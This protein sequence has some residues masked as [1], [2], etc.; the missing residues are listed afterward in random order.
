MALGVPLGGGPN[1][2]RVD[3]RHVLEPLDG[4]APS[5]HFVGTLG[6]ERLL[7]PRS[8]EPRA[9]EAEVPPASFTISP[10]SAQVW[11]AHPVCA[12]V[13]ASEAVP[14]IRSRATGPVTVVAPGY[15]PVTVDPATVGEIVLQRAP[16]IGSLVVAAA[17]GDQVRV[18]GLAV[19]TD[20]D[21]VVVKD[22]REGTVVVQV[23]G[24]GRSFREELAA[25]EGYGL[26]VRVPPP[27]VW[28][29]R[30]AANS[31]AISAEGR[32]R[33]GQLV[34]E[35]GDAV[36]RLTGSHSEEG[37]A[38]ANI[39]LADRR[40]RAVRDALVAAGMPADRLVVTPSRELDR[41]AP[42]DQRAVLI[43]AVGR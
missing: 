17:P 30:F 37:T 34:E 21:G 8:R 6:V 5:H 35:A 15:L 42:E 28:E 25:A 23:V 40:A 13:P 27:P 2:I 3:A 38:K 33:L 24:G 12:W 36:F 26:W 43:Q 19:A 16:A 4:A 9:A 7:G 31:A 11:I 29:V 10:A 41:P 14:I 22:V 1:V 39:E 20:A 32:A 18:D